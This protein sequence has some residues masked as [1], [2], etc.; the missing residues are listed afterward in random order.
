MSKTMPTAAGER[1]A[2][3]DRP[4]AE[5]LDVRAVADMLGISVRTVY[6][7]SDA[8]RIPAPV[9]LGALVR[10]PRRAVLDWIAAGCPAV[11]TVGRAER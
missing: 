4:P 2:G 9:K 8:G 10:W 3:P 11:R 6:R 5:L 1:V 7:L